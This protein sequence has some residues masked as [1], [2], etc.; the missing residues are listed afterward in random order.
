MAYGKKITEESIKNFCRDAG[1]AIAAEATEDAKQTAFDAL[2]SNWSKQYDVQQITDVQVE[3]FFE[4]GGLNLDKY[5]RRWLEPILVAKSEK[6]TSFA[7]LA[8][9]HMPENDGFIHSDKEIAALMRFLNSADLQSQL[10][11][12]TDYSTEVLGALS[13]MKDVNWNTEG[14]PEAIRKFMNCKLPE[15]AVLDCVK[16]FN[17]IARVDN[18]DNGHREAIRISCVNHYKE[19]L[20]SLD[21]PRKQKNCEEQIKYLEGP[22]ACGTLVGGKAPA[23]HIIRAF[24]DNGSS[25][26]TVEIKSL[27]DLKGKVVL[28][29]F[30]GTKCV[31]CIQSFPEIAEL[32]KHFDG[33][34]VVILG[35]TSLQGYFVDTPNHRTI[36]CRNNPEKELGCFPDFMKAMNVNWTIAVTEEN[37][38]NT[39]F[40]VLAIPHVTI[41]D[42]EGKVRYNAVNLDNEEKSKLIESLLAE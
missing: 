15:L 32:Q 28:I 9:K 16:A 2:A 42:K 6:D 19:L 20:K 1:Q 25:V 18:V 3:M 27:D 4:N 30:W 11:S 31:P 24:K 23:I 10:D 26:E 21:N 33:K 37:V 13:T 8:W 35:I 17:S 14:F 40:G 7:F 39:D 12:H 22:F 34:D 41:I 5:M 36:Q 38:M 29:D